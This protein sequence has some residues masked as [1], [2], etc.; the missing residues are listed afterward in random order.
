MQ[1]WCVPVLAGLVVFFSVN[2]LTSTPADAAG[3]YS[4]RA[5]GGGFRG[6][7]LFRGNKLARQKFVRSRRARRGGLFRGR[8]AV[9][10]RLAARRAFR[11][12]AFAKGRMTR[13]S[14]FGAR[15]RPWSDTGRFA[16]K[17]KGG[18]FRA[19]R[20]GHGE[21]AGIHRRHGAF[22]GHWKLRRA[23]WAAK[24][25][26]LVRSR[27]GLRRIRSPFRG[28]KRRWAGRIKPISPF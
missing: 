27:G 8:G 26:S 1:R 23:P 24:R 10:G 4:V 6:V 21:L 3:M 7:R 20:R 18:I 9:R 12:R 17:R 16:V 2:H 13:G 22:A 15:H 25:S 11:Q 28:S 5:S 19:S 14:L